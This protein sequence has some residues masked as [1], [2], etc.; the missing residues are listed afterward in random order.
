MSETQLA[1]VQPAAMTAPEGKQPSMLQAVMQA[2]M[3]PDLDPERVE[4][5]LAMGMQLEAD[6]RAQEFAAAFAAASLQI[7]A[8]KIT[9]AGE[10]TYQGKNGAPSSVI[11][12]IKHDDISRVIKP[13]LAEHGLVATYSAEILPNPPKAVTVMTVMHRNGH[14]REWR[15]IPMPLV[16][17]G[18]GKNDVQGA[19]SISTYGRRFVTVA[20]FDIVAE[21]DDNDGNLNAT[22]AHP[23]TQ[24]QADTIANILH[25]LNN[26]EPGSSN[27]FNNWI[28]QQFRVESV[29]QLL[30]GDQYQEVMAK[31]NE[32][33]RAAGMKR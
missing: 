33:Q 27:K 19:G 30:Q 26:R 15:S 4:K 21:G 3:N 28:R 24:D 2:A 12:F 32:K 9:K 8:I 17:S 31:L 11:K 20:A 10:I 23:I 25:E 13:I 7:S 5:F 29:G 14:S 16:D 6:K 22:Q 18:G 1:T